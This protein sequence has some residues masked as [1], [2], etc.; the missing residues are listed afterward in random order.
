[1]VADDIIREEIR[2]VFDRFLKQVLK[3]FLYLVKEIN[4]VEI[5][6]DTSE[7]APYIVLAVD[8]LKL[9]EE[10]QNLLFSFGY[11][12]NKA[13]KTVIAPDFPFVE[14]SVVRGSVQGN[15]LIRIA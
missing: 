3:E 14:V 13:L 11:R 9:P 6:I 4:E 2:S 10:K 1:M 15:N 7:S 8:Y 5:Y 12:L